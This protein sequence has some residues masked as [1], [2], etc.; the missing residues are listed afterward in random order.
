LK[1]CGNAKSSDKEYFERGNLRIPRQRLRALL[2]RDVV[3][4]D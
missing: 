3:A 1:V 4:L 2:L